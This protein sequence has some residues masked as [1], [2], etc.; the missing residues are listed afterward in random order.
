[1]S[2]DSVPTTGASGAPEQAIPE[3]R[4]R[5]PP[6]VE[7]LCEIHFAESTWDETVPGAFYERVKKDFPGKRQQEIREAQITLGPAEAT[8]GMRRLPPRMQFV[9]DERHRMIQIAKDLLVVNQ[10]AF[11]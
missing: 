3:R 6:V 2:K 8:A 10:S 7:A 4:Y 11:D 5:K 9:S 1:M